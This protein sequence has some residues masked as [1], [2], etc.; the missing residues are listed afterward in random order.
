MP[1]S[2]LREWRER[3]SG[4]LDEIL[5]AHTLVG[6]TDRGRR[7]ATQQLNRAYAVLLASHFQGFCRDIHSECSD[8]VARAIEPSSLRAIVR[9]QLIHGRQLDRGNAQP[10]SL[11]SDFSRLGVEF[12]TEVERLRANNERYKRLLIE[13]NDW[14]NALVHQDFDLAKLGGSVTLTLKR[15]KLWRTACEQLSYSFDQVMR[16][17]LRALTGTSPW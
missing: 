12:W 13:L 7:F 17:H 10:A 3:R 5:S 16:R 8:F 4:E 15:V 6:G 11:G 2:A 9:A 1:S 14:R